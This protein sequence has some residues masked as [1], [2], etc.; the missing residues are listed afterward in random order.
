MHCKFDGGKQ[1]NRSQGGAWEGRCKGAGPRQNH[2]PTWGPMVRE[3]ITGKQPNSV[4]ARV[5]ENRSIQ[6][7]AD[8]KRKNSEAAKK[9]RQQSK[10]RKTN[11]NSAQARNDYACP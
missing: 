11:D 10:Y 9:S 6:V 1:V 2:G 8:R 4:F 3:C 5:A 7:T